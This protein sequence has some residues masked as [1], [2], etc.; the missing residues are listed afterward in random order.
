MNAPPDPKVLDFPTLDA[1]QWFRAERTLTWAEATLLLGVSRPALRRALDRARLD[2]GHRPLVVHGSIAG[3]RFT[4]TRPV[5][6]RGVAWRFFIHGSD[7][8]AAS[9]ISDLRTAI[10]TSANGKTR[11]RGLLGVLATPLRW[12]RGHSGRHAS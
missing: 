7:S 9:G 5:V 2:A 12:L 4:A 10:A 6:A 11:P 3:H 1:E 8:G